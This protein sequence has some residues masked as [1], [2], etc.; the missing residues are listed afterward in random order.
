[1]HFLTEDAVVDL[2]I[3][4]DSIFLVKGIAIE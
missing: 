4:H 3:L 2:M 1:L